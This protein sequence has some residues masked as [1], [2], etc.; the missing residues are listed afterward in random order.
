MNVLRDTYH[1]IRH[2]SSAFWVVIAATLMNQMGNM[3]FVFLILYL[4]KHLGFS[5]SQSSFSFVIFSLSMVLSG[6]FGGGYVDKLGAARV[7]MASIFINGCILLCFPFLRHYGLILFFCMLWGTA[8]GMFRPASQTFISQL[9]SPGMHKITFSVYR[10]A[11]NLGM[12]VGPAIGGFL[13]VHSFA[14]I[15]VANA[16]ANISASIILLVGLRGSSWLKKSN[17]ANLKP[18][19]NL[20]WLLID[21]RL[22]IFIFGLIPVSMVFFQHEATLPIYL[23]RDLHLSLSFYGLLFTL[24]TLMIV[25]FELPLNVATINWPYRVNFS[26]GTILIS[27]GFAGLAFSTQAWHVVLITMVWTTGE[28]LLYPSASSYIADI[29]PEDRRGSYMSLYSSSSN[30]GMMLGPWAGAI[31]MQHCGAYCL[32]LAC[33]AWGLL[34]LGFFWQCKKV[35]PS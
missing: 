29:A 34:S 11:V 13:A 23:S 12:S 30:L 20:R 31:V 17:Q 33:G 24:N 2:F 15:F 28:M 3:A 18:A 32:W 35:T 25:F 8:F 5:L 26:I 4:S 10:L 27:L 6:I 9:S 16:I 22:R 7:M 14:A 1:H 21:S 19:Y